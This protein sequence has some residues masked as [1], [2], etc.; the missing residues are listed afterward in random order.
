MADIRI[1]RRGT[2]QKEMASP[3]EYRSHDL[4]S[5][6]CY[7]LL[8]FLQFINY[9]RFLLAFIF[10]W[11]CLTEW[12][13]DHFCRPKPARRN[14]NQIIHVI[15]ASCQLRT[16]PNKFQVTGFKTKTATDV[17]VTAV[18]LGLYAIWRLKY[19]TKAFQA[20]WVVTAR[21]VNSLSTS[22]TQKL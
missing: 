13:G 19:G 21:D 14:S 2:W 22:A 17:R 3:I 4:V 5:L 18:Y 11:V 8:S 15:R 12:A 20:L 9:S 16:R 10:G 6:V 7:V 1:R